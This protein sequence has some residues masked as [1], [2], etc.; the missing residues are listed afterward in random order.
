MELQHTDGGNIN[1]TTTLENSSTIFKKLNMHPQYNS[2]IPLLGFC[3]REKENILISIPVYLQQ[4]Y[5]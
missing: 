4:I 5:L 2:V 1:G 3:P